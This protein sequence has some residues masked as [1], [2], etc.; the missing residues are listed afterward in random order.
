MVL[1]FLREVNLSL[2][3]WTCWNYTISVIPNS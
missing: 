1:V 2:F 3:W